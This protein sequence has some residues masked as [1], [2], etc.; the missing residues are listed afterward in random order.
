MFG[1]APIHDAPSAK[2]EEPLT[3]QAA[4]DE[5]IAEL[6]RNGHILERRQRGPRAVSLETELEF[7]PK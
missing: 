6:K 7:N 5:L 2:P 3:D 1:S 4:L